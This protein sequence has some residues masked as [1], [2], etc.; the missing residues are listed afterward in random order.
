VCGFGTHQCDA[1]GK[2]DG[3]DGGSWAK[4]SVSLSL[5]GVSHFRAFSSLGESPVHPGLAT[6]SSPTSLPS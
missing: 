2:E 6:V 5:L 3:G 1:R 4:A